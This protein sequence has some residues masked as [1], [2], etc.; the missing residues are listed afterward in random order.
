MYQKNRW[1]SLDG[2]TA[3][4]EISALHAKGLSEDV[5]R[6][7]HRAARIS[8]LNKRLKEYHPIFVIMY[9]LGYKDIYEQ[10][11][12]DPF[13]NGFAWQGSTLCALVEHPTARP[14][15]LAEWWINKGKD[16]WSMI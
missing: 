7:T 5:E 12:G 13:R 14:G 11:V 16:I 2:E 6:V 15:K 1:G 4:L 8:T 3:V 9:A 10:I